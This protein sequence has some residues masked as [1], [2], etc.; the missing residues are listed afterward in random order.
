M[1]REREKETWHGIGVVV[2][3]VYVNGFY[4]IYNFAFALISLVRIVGDC[5][6]MPFN[7]NYL[8]FSYFFFFFIELCV[9]WFARTQA[10][11][12]CLL[13]MN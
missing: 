2:V 3:F 6:G 12:K 11:T 10:H 9:C 8:Y 7:V 13:P 4:S 5:I 1:V